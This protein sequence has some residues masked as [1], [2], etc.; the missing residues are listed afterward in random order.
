MIRGLVDG[1]IPFMILPGR[2][3]ENASADHP[4]GLRDLG[5]GQVATLFADLPLSRSILAAEYRT[6]RVGA[7]SQ[8]GLS[9]SPKTAMLVHRI[10]TRRSRRQRGLAVVLMISCSSP[11]CGSTAGQHAGGCWRIDETVP[12]I[13]FPSG[14][15]GRRREVSQLDL[16][17]LGKARFR[18]VSRSATKCG[19]CS[20]V[21]AVV[22]SFNSGRS[23]TSRRLSLRGTSTMSAP[24]QKWRCGRLLQSFS[25]RFWGPH[26]RAFGLRSRS[27]WIAGGTG[28]GDR[29]LRDAFSFITPESPSASRCSVLRPALEGLGPLTAQILGLSMVEIAI[30]IIAGS[31][32]FHRQGVRE[33][34]MDLGES[35]TA[36]SGRPPAE[37][38]HGSSRARVGFA[39]RSMISYRAACPG[40]IDADRPIYLILRATR[41]YS[42]AQTRSRPSRSSPRRSSSS[43]RSSSTVDQPARRLRGQATDLLFGVS[44][45]RAPPASQGRRNVESVI[46]RGPS[47]AALSLD[48]S[49]LVRELARHELPDKATE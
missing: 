7:T 16:E 43:W 11:R 9:A 26:R 40:A 20:G 1:Y 6:F 5:A 18:W 4:R 37:L 19:R 10:V 36:R 2:D 42:I 33:A 45:R 13:G 30:R 15:A 34:A 24:S 29:Q 17:T 14:G 35:P 44:S 3:A 23:Q 28:K 8:D 25:S 46:L 31:A 12:R 32:C 47:T 22:D 41:P 21:I 38:G 39:R 49:P 27:R 48:S